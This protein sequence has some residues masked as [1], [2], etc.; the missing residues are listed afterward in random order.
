MSGPMRPE[1]SRSQEGSDVTE[2]V[3]WADKV[4]PLLP[5]RT[6]H[7]HIAGVGDEARGSGNLMDPIV[8]AVKAYATLGEIARALKDVFG[9]HKEAVK[10]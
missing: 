4:A 5:P 6:I 1:E 8:E 2:R 7:V 10:F 3:A 9:E